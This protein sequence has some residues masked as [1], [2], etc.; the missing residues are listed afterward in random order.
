MKKSLIK[1]WETDLQN[2][3]KQRDVLRQVGR[4]DGAIHCR[5][6]NAKLGELSWLKKRNTTYFINNAEF[7]AGKECKLN[8]TYTNFQENLIMGNRFSHIDLNLV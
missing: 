4:K 3:Q 8:Q 2:E 1:G 7:F 5:K 6:C